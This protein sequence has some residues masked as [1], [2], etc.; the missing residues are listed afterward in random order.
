[1]RH[2][3]WSE[4]PF[5]RSLVR[6]MLGNASGAVVRE[7]KGSAKTYGC[8]STE[9][10]YE[11]SGTT[12]SESDWQTPNAEVHGAQEG[13]PRNCGQCKIR[14]GTG[15]ECPLYELRTKSEEEEVIGRCDL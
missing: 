15:M 4:R 11:A 2:D 10:S 3:E 6:A 8:D 9:Q 13:G 1:M 7:E 14:R 5:G 12:H